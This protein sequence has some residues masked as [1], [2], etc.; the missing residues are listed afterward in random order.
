MLELLLSL[1]GFLLLLPFFAVLIWLRLIAY[2]KH[3]GE[4]VQVSAASLLIAAICCHLGFH[5]EL[6]AHGGT[7]IW[8]Q[9]LA[10]MC[11]FFSFLLIF[12]AAWWHR[13]RANTIAQ[14]TT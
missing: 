3:I 8:P 7:L 14:K 12:G 4:T 9:A 10:A 13:R 1:L 6:A 2:P 5:S 11:A